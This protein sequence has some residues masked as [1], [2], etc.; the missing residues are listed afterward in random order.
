MMMKPRFRESADEKAARLAGSIQRLHVAA[1]AETTLESAQ[2]G[3]PTLEIVEQHIAANL[4]AACSGTPALA[5]AVA[6]KTAQEGFNVARSLLDGAINHQDLTGEQMANLEA[7]I[8][9]IGRPAWFVNSDAPQT[10]AAG[11]ADEFWIAHILAAHDALLDVCARVGCIML[12]DADPL[13]PVATGWLI[14]KNTLVTNAHVATGV[15]RQNV[16]LANSDAR[17][18]W[19]LRSDR[20]CTVDFAFERGSAKRS[21]FAIDEVLYVEDQGNPDIAVFRLKVP[22]GTPPPPSP[23]KLDLES[24]PGGWTRT[25]VFVAGHP[26][27]DLSDDRNVV[28][29]FGDLDGTKRFCPGYTLQILGNEVLTHDCSTTS[30]SSGSPLIDFATLQAVALHYFGKPG[31]RNEAVLLSAIADHP[32]IAKSRSGDWGI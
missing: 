6:N 11:A 10:E 30:G 24:R 3:L 29:V 1:A 17:R 2:A 19:R 14:G 20:R 18:G 12:G 31:E 22:D 4:K 25:R 21:R 9:V 23:I 32:A 16:A 7:V 5:E 27:K 13:A 26:I 8:Q 15:A 28:T